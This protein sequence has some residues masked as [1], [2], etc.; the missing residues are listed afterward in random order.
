MIIDGFP[1]AA[2]LIALGYALLK[3]VTG[4]KGEAA[5]YF[6]K[7]AEVFVWVMV[8]Y[9]ALNIADTFLK[10]EFSLTVEGS[11]K[12][13]GNDIHYLDSLHR[14]ALDWLFYEA[15]V[16]AILQATIILAPL[17]NT[18]NAA[19]FP[20]KMV[21]TYSISFILGA[22]FL[23]LLILPYYG[24]LLT[25][26]AS[27]L[28]VPEIRQLGAPLYSVYL[29]YGPTFLLIARAARDALKNPAVAAVPPSA[30]WWDLG[31]PDLLI[32]VASKMSQASLVIFQT[33]VHIMAGLVIAGAI[34][35]AV[36]GALGGPGIRFRV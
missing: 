7:G 1:V 2:V 33:A 22:Y 16:E 14:K 26:G 10:N 15:K 35:L 21:L 20:W 3:Y 18:L 29:V 5:H 25:I 11:W 4:Q 27:L 31:N 24:A 19:T 34:S 30:N 12:A 9:L 32:N 17:A 6:F 13:L 8:P 23:A 28:T 36:S